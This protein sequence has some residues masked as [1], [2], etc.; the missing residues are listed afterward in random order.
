M[1]DISDE[2]NP[3]FE[4]SHEALPSN[5]GWMVLDIESEEEN[6][7][8]QL[9]N[10]VALEDHFPPPTVD[11]NT[12]QELLISSCSG[13]LI[14]KRIVEDANLYSFQKTGTS[15]KTNEKEIDQLPGI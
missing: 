15:M 14:T 10:D 1:S 9:R 8:E 6:Q 4:I 11:F 7:H 12:Q 3:D 2:D 5:N 13:Q